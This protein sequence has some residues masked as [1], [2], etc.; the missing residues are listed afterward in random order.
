MSDAAEISAA[1]EAVEASDVPD[2]AATAETAW[3]AAVLD[4][5]E[6]ALA[7]AEAG[8]TEQTIDRTPDPAGNQPSAQESARA[9]LQE[10][11]SDAERAAD[12]R[13]REQREDT[14]R[15]ARRD[16]KRRGKDR[17]APPLQ[18]DARKQVA[19]FVGVVAL[20]GAATWLAQSGRIPIP[21]RNTDAHAMARPSHQTPSP[22]KAEV[23]AIVQAAHDTPAPSMVEMPEIAAAAAEPAPRE[24]PPAIEEA[25]LPP[26]PPPVAQEPLPAAPAGASDQPAG[27]NSGEPVRL[28]A[29]KTVVLATKDAGKC[30]YRG[31]EVKTVPV[32][33]S[34]G[35]DGKVQQV[36]VKGDVSNRLTGDCIVS[37]LSA[38]TIPPFSGEPVSVRA[39]V[40]IH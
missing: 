14:V 29:L 9:A 34:F 4:A 28:V 25:A 6:T 33:V 11:A 26:E 7:E 21:F 40:P 12:E 17:Q 24:I 22:A 27:E 10:S 32:I 1:S 15:T 31:D 16:A 20:L 3:K 8:V 38:L 39:D 35:N 30:R 36:V 2:T 18:R 19:L 23:H 37:K 5:V 13:A